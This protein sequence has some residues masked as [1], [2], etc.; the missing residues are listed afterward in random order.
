MPTDRGAWAADLAP[1]SPAA[2][3][4]VREGDIV[5]EVNGQPAPSSHELRLWFGQNPPGTVVKLKVRRQESKEALVVT[6]G[7]PSSEQHPAAELTPVGRE[8]EPA[9]GDDEP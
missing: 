8:P 9:A 7:P 6:L 1:D 5:V 4:G 2:K 3:A